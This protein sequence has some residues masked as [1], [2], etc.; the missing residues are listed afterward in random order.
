[1]K[2]AAFAPLAMFLALTLPHSAA[3][4]SS[5]TDDGLPVPQAVQGVLDAFHKPLHPIVGGVAPG[6]GMGV[7]IGYTTPK[8]EDWFHNADAR[9]TINRYW[10]LTGETGRRTERSSISVLGQI[11]HM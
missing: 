3:A 9:I 1:M 6:G 11:R 2:Y 8:T 5:G 4:Q 7:G 10:S